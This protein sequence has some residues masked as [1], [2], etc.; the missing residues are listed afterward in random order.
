MQPL[1]TRLKIDPSVALHYIKTLTLKHCALKEQLEECWQ[2]CTLRYYNA[3]PEVRVVYVDQ[4]NIGALAFVVV[5]MKVRT[6]VIE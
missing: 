2:Y 1:V 6:C 4:V 5:D 3:I